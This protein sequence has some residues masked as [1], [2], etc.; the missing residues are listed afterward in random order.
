MKGIRTEA[1]L[2]RLFLRQKL[3]VALLSTLELLRGALLS[4]MVLPGVRKTG[5]PNLGCPSSRPLPLTTGSS[6]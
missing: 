5:F 2:H 1:N 3:R 4:T 6:R